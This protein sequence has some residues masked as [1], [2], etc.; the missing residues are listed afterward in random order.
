M[1]GLENEQFKTD[2]E[3]IRVDSAG[4]TGAEGIVVS[5]EVT[6][7][8]DPP[9]SNLKRKNGAIAGYEPLLRIHFLPP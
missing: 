6:A 8:D 5:E 2:L 4:D 1:V 7:T 9:Y 3:K